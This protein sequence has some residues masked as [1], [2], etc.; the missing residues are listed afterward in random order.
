MENIDP[1]LEL[2]ARKQIYQTVLKSPGLHF[3][4]LQR[5]TDFV[6]GVLQYHLDY[7]KKNGLLVEEKDRDYSRFFV[8]DEMGEDDRRVLSFLRQRTVRK[9]LM[10]LLVN[11]HTK[12]KDIAREVSV[13]PSTLSWHLK[14]LTD[15]G[16]LLSDTKGRESY[17]SILDSNR[18]IR[19]LV[20]YRASFLDKLVDQ[21]IDSW[22]ER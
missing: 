5:R 1:A 20:T 18:I 3:R 2:E 10:H 7:L 6:T 19:L 13:S 8:V 22:T 11:P 14:R 21:F 17:F 16:V 15:A 12:H 4:E 9:I